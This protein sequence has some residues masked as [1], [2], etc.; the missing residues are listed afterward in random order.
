MSL[1]RPCPTVDFM[2]L[3]LMDCAKL[4]RVGLITLIVLLLLL[5]CR[6]SSAQDGGCSPDPPNTL[7]P[8]G[9]VDG[10][11]RRNMLSNNV[12]VILPDS[13]VPDTIFRSLIGGYGIN[14]WAV[15]SESQVRQFG[16]WCQVRQVNTNNTPDS[17]IGDWY[18]PT[19][20]GGFT[21]LTN[22]TN[23]GTPYQSL[24]CTDQIGLVVDGNVTN[25]QGIVRCTTTVPGLNTDSNYMAVYKDS[26]FG[27]LRACK[28][29]KCMSG[30]QYN[31][32]P[33]LL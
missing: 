9:P 16:L 21:I 15:F 11:N 6:Y 2:A 10:G 4:L 28:L 22:T 1:K 30:A 19:A 3:S 24:K 27:S 18:Y 29:L 7:I 12:P 31:Y 20:S 13:G 14:T 33:F 32:T 23:D 5:M 8:S 25:Y 26:V 17:N